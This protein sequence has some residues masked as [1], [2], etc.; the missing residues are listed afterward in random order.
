MSRYD[1]IYLRAT[2]ETASPEARWLF[3]VLDSYADQNG[4][5]TFRP[6]LR[7]LLKRSGMGRT[8]FYKVRQ[9]LIEKGWVKA[10]ETKASNGQ[11]TATEYWTG[12]VPQNGT[13][14]VKEKGQKKS[15]V[16]VS[17]MTGLKLNR[18]PL[19]LGI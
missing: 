16:K 1:R 13:I 8:K 9:E 12:V 18:K 15:K 6:A 7:L 10:V 4:K 5:P 2:D 17:R 14:E 3:V 19:L 11:P